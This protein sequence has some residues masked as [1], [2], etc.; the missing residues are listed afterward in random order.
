MLT[1]LIPGP[2]SHGKDMDVY[3]RPV[4]NELKDLWEQRDQIR[5][6]VDSSVF[7]AYCAHVNSK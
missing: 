7:N 6:A 3:L 5:A 2:N 1:L 4:V